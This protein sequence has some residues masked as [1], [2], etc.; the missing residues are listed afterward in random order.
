MR[1]PLAV[2]IVRRGVVITLRLEN[3][4]PLPGVNEL[5]ELRWRDAIA[6]FVVANETGEP[7]AVLGCFHLPFPSAAPLTMRRAVAV[8]TAE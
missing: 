8:R 2:S 3:V 6:L 1:P 4:V 5:L 7:H